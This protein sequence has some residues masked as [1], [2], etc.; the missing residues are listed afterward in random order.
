MRLI[1]GIIYNDLDVDYVG[2]CIN[3]L[4][5]L[6]ALY[7]CGNGSSLLGGLRIDCS[8]NFAEMRNRFI[9]HIE[10][11]EREYCSEDIWLLWLDAD[12]RLDIRSRFEFLDNA[13]KDILG[14]RVNISN[15]H[16]YED[17]WRMVQSNMIRLLRLFRGVEF[18]G[19]I[20][21][22]SL[23]SIKRLGGEVDSSNVLIHH[24]GYD[25]LWI[26]ILEKINRNIN[27]LQSIPNK[28][29]GDYYHLG[30]S[31]CLLKDYDIALYWFHKALPLLYGNIRNDC[32][33]KIIGI[34][35]NLK[36]YDKCKQYFDM[37]D[38]RGM[39][40]TEYRSYEDLCKNLIS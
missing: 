12:E 15:C 22:S 8:G 23:D 11:C 2:N 13:S 14:Y 35:Y 5:G 4:V 19:S 30:Q 17:G 24:L 39:N 9:N 37:L 32:L 6:D 21:E 38:R 10:F 36:Q 28:D 20:H 3:S 25:K 27:L 1:G 16:V 34:Y 18:E 26:D 29:P 33:V 7:L 40:Q 31:H